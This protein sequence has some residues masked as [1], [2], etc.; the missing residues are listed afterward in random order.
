M[1]LKCMLTKK[2]PVILAD[3]FA[4][5]KVQKKGFKKMLKKIKK[6]KKSS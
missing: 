5:R 2:S 3:D 6:N 4:K 1:R